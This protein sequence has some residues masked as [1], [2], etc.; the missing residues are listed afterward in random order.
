MVL[1]EQKK[2]GMPDVFFNLVRLRKENTPEFEDSFSTVVVDKSFRI[3]GEDNIKSFCASLNDAKRLSFE[4]T[5]DGRMK[6]E[7][8]Y[9]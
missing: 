2:V 4:P 3:N 8:V 7:I 1:S 9:K 6:M 5:N